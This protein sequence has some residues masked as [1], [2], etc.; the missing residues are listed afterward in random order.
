MI[1]IR[2]HSLLLRKPLSQELKM[3]LEEMGYEFTPPL[4]LEYVVTSNTNV[5]TTI[6][7]DQWD[8]KKNPHLCWNIAG[9][10]DLGT[11]F[12]KFVKL[13]GPV[14]MELPDE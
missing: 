4:D 14:L 12:D 9:R 7:E 10:K 5:V 1:I 3:I 8:G 6:S 2:E 11:D 13:A